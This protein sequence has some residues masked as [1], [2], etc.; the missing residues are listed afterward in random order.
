MKM[1]VHSTSDLPIFK[2]TEIPIFIFYVVFG[3]VYMNFCLSLKTFLFFDLNRLLTSL[4]CYIPP[5]P[6]LKT[7]QVDLYQGSILSSAPGT[8]G[9]QTAMTTWATSESRLSTTL[10]ALTARTGGRLAAGAEDGRG[11]SA[12]ALPQRLTLSSR[13]GSRSR[14]RGRYPFPSASRQGGSFQGS[15]GL[16]SSPTREYIPTQHIL[17]IVYVFWFWGMPE[18]NP[19]F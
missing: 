16:G 7:P 17:P 9:A 8:D 4:D 13:R 15:R 3:G 18:K 14:R 6:Y 5:M 11:G 2:V 19:C 1:M 10:E 12:R